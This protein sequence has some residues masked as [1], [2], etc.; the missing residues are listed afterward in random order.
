MDQFQPDK[1]IEGI[2]SPREYSFAVSH[3]R[4]QI[5]QHYQSAARGVEATTQEIISEEEYAQMSA[6]E[7]LLD[8]E[9]TDFDFDSSRGVQGLDPTKKQTEAKI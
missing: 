2:W 4:Q 8:K 5:L 6:N 3:I 7:M 1:D 9:P